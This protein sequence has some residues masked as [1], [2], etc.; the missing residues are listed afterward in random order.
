MAIGSES[1]PTLNT[2]SMRAGWIGFLIMPSSGIAQIY[3][4]TMPSVLAPLCESDLAVATAIYSLLQSVGLVRGVTIADIVFNYR[5]YH[6]LYLSPD[7]DV[8]RCSEVEEL[9]P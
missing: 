2:E 1:F 8:N 7:D 3:T 6:Y 5:L 9:T 4:S